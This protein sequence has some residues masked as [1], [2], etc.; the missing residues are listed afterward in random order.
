MRPLAYL[1]CKTVTTACRFDVTMSLQP[2]GKQTTNKNFIGLGF[3]FIQ[4]DR[5]YSQN[6]R[7]YCEQ[8]PN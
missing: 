8:I 7:K 2:F 1:Q 5:G 4:I 6:S 3:N